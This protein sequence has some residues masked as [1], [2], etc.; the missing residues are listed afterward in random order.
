MSGDDELVSCPFGV[1][2]YHPLQVV[3]WYCKGPWE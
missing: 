2:R 3:F 1:L